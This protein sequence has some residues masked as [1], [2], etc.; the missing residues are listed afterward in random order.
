MGSMAD[1][2]TVD[3]ERR[4]STGVVVAAQFEASIREGSIVVLFGPSGSGKT[5]VVRS[6]A[7]LDRPD[8]GVIR[9][10]HDVWLD[11]DAGLF[12]EPQGRRVGYVFQEAAL[13]PHL[14]VR[15][16]VEYGLRHLPEAARTARSREL[17]AWVG[18]SD[19]A[20][21]HPGHLSGGQAQRVALARALAPEPRLLLLDEP[22]ASIDAPARAE[23][24]RL[25]RQSVRR[26]DMACVVV[27]HDRTEAIALGDEM[28]VLA[29][30]RVRQVGPV[31]DVF[32]RPANLIVARSVGV[33]SVLDASV[34]GVH[35]GL[36]DL[37][38]GD[39]ILHAADFG[40]DRH[41]REVFAC[42]RAEDVTLGRS[43]RGAVSTR[44]HLAGQVVLIEAEGP[45][46]RIS[47][48]CGFPLAALITRHAREE[49]GLVEGTVVTAA[50]KATA[51][52][53][54][55]RS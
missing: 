5:T 29:E 54:V 23:L 30:G 2:L 15:A 28:V 10:G 25:L 46:E 42:I 27:T 21:R 11:T 22:F 48:D 24:R 55:P 19:Y 20:E 7:G 26:L 45:V 32:R 17:I 18:L 53:L 3:L 12:V 8:R 40:L 44:N 49:M 13:F 31:A 36:V 34:E 41:V 47:V 33:E 1:A 43:F 14:T 37:R 51:V 38:V 52:H 6:I 16:N 39:A 9:F 50:I 4:F 35:D